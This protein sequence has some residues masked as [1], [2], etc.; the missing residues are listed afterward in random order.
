MTLR[1]I[2]KALAQKRGDG[3]WLTL[4]PYFKSPITP[5]TPKTA[6]DPVI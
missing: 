6:A 5:S 3:R 4:R 1:V 2:H